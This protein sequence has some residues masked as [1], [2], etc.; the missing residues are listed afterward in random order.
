MFHS[1][2]FECM[3]ILNNTPTKVIFIVFN[4]MNPKI[5]HIVGSTLKIDFVL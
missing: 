3:K 2:K 5:V 1:L 4:C